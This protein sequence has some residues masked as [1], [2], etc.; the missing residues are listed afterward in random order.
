VLFVGNSPGSH[1]EHEED[2]KT[3]KDFLTYSI[4]VFVGNSPGSHKE[5]KEDTKT[6]KEFATYS[7]FILSPVKH[8]QINEKNNVKMMFYTL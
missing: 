6:T 2:T 3:T 7:I 5:Q 4:V 8:R 1:E